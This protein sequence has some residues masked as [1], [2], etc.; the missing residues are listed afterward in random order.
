[1]LP[2]KSGIVAPA[3]RKKEEEKE[4]EREKEEMP[5]LSVF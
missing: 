3:K 5:R 4:E 1:M 2:C